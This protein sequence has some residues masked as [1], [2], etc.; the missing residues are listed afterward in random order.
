MVP[1]SGGGLAAISGD[2]TRLIGVMQRRAVT[3][4]AALR[5]DVSRGRFRR[6]APPATAGPAGV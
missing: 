6:P 3:A 2:R 5:A 1:A 4:R